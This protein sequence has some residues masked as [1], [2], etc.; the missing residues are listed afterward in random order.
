MLHTHL[1]EQSGDKI[2]YRMCFIYLL[3]KVL[4]FQNKVKIDLGSVS[5][6]GGESIFK[7]LKNSIVFESTL[8]VEY[9][10]SG[11]RS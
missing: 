3:K 6:E 11:S 2:N 7:L 10:S 9:R 5:E 1:K 4:L 8:S